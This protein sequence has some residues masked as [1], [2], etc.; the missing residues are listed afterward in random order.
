MLT[1][2]DLEAL[3]IPRLSRFDRATWRPT[4]EDPVARLFPPTRQHE[5]MDVEGMG[6]ATVCIFTSGMRLSFTAVTL[7]STL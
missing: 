4:F 5:G 3:D 7:N 2:E 1:L 6:W